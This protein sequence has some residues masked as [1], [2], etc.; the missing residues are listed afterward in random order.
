MALIAMAVHD[1][2]ENNRTPLTLKCLI[3]VCR[4]VSFSKHR[5]FII[6]NNSCK[7]TK[8]V[9]DSFKHIE[10][11]KVI[12]LPENI[13]T[14]AAINLAWKQRGI[15]EHCIKMDNDVVIHNVGWI[16]EMEEAIRRQ[17]LIGQVGLKRKDCWEHPAHENPDYKSVLIDLPHEPGQTWITVEKCKHIIGT[18]VMHSAALIDKV[19]GMWQPTL[20][21]H[22][23][24]L[25]SWRSQ[26][27]GF[28]NVF[29]RHINIDHIDPGGTAYQAWKEDEGGRN[30]KMVSDIVDEYLKGTRSIVYPL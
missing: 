14:A 1:T 25:M 24:V 26:I 10:N 23:D 22:D 3:S 28:I 15:T 30:G 11:I 9:L 4:T 5:L 21:G 12:H 16:E 20:Y 29:L 2:A 6:D 7:E 18:C 8:E 19:G 17:P 13:G 27:A